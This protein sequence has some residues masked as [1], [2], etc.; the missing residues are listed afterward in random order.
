MGRH[1]VQLRTSFS[2][3]IL[4]AEELQEMPR[5]RYGLKPGGTSP[6]G[7]FSLPIMECIGACDGAPAMLVDEDLHIDLSEARIIEILA[8]YGQE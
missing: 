5:Q 3:M 2:C 1:L 6:A 4:G 7:G 8:G